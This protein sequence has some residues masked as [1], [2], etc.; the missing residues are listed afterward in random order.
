[1]PDAGAISRWLF[2]V[3]LVPL[4]VGCS[5]RKLAVSKLADTLAETGTSFA[6]DE[7]PELIRDAVPF[8]LKT[9]EA[10]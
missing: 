10:Y 3:L 5:V 1:M 2:L 8:A 7:D 6:S 4:I 9:M